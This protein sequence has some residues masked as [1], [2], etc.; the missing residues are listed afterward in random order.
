MT[1][2]HS[3]R[4]EILRSK[5]G[6]CAD[7]LSTSILRIPSP[8]VIPRHPRLLDDPNSNLTSAINPPG[9]TNKHHNGNKT[10]LAMKNRWKIR[11]IVGY[12]RYVISTILFQRTPY[13][14]NS[15][16]NFL[17]HVF[18]TYQYRVLN[19]SRDSI[20]YFLEFF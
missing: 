2:P 13:S 3:I 6:H 18:K 9:S 17:K 4:P 7:P 1:R 14:H 15:T 16:G 19:S 11:K 8:D 5:K 12:Q 20:S 10:L